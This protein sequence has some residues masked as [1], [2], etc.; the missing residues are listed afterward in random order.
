M[1]VKGLECITFKAYHSLLLSFLCFS[2]FVLLAAST[3]TMRQRESEIQRD[4]R[5][6]MPRDCEK[7]RLRERENSSS[8]VFFR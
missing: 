2:L 3:K 7:L 8:E 1:R 6:E 5:E 4:L